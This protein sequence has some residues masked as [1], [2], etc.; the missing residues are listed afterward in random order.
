MQAGEL[1]LIV[2]RF[3]MFDQLYIHTRSEKSELSFLIMA[4]TNTNQS[5]L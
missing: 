2:M 5:T 1:E 4:L 3:L